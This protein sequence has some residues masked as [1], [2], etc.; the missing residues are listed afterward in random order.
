MRKLVIVRGLP[1]SGKGHYIDAHYGDQDP[2]ICSSDHFFMVNGDY[3]FDVKKLGESHATS[4]AKAI[5]AM[6]A[7]APL[8]VADNTFSRRWEWS[9]YEAAGKALGYEVVIVD[10]FDGGCSDEELAGRN[11]H[12]VPIQYITPMR[13][14]WENT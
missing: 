7:G 10:L 3:V 8:V 14:R 11:V 9:V 13:E 5:D 4:Q 2:V 12:N 6:A 1:G